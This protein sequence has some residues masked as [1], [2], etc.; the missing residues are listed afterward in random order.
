MA[1]T[2]PDAK[3]A[4]VFANP[5]CTRT[6]PRVQQLCR[7]SLPLACDICAP[8]CV[9]SSPGAPLIT[10]LSHHLLHA[11]LERR[12]EQVVEC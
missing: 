10:S 3:F 6:L 7:R 4:D 1:A 11:L 8:P 5:F 2:V 9:P 12:V